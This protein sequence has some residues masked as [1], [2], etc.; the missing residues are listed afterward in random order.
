MSN[1]WVGPKFTSCL[2]L[3]IIELTSC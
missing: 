2:H 1:H 3:V